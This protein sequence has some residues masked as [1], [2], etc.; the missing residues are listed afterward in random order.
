[1]ARVLHAPR[2]R[3]ERTDRS[4]YAHKG[5]PDGSVGAAHNAPAAILEATSRC[6]T[7]L[8]LTQFAAASPV[9][10]W[11]LLILKGEMAEWFKAHAWKAWSAVVLR[12]VLQALD[13]PQPADH[14]VP[15]GAV[16]VHQSRKHP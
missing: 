2:Y 8:G 5:N 11:K 12:S 3:V 15:T 10:S 16:L 9:V 4:E 6:E 7:L 14:W 1:M 13:P